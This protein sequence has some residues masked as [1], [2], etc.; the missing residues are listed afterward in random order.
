MRL[1]RCLTRV[2]LFQGMSSDMRTNSATLQEYH[3]FQSGHPYYDVFCKLATETSCTFQCLFCCAKSRSRDPDFEWGK[4]TLMTGDGTKCVGPQR[5]AERFSGPAQ[6]GRPKRYLCPSQWLA[7]MCVG[8]TRQWAQYLHVLTSSWLFI[9]TRSNG[10]QT[11]PPHHH[12]ERK[13]G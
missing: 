7:D 5:E 4:K 1:V 8:D 6:Q 10:F 2:V 9:L 11:L 12:P 13:S 3:I